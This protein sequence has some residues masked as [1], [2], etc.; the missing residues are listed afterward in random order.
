[1][2]YWDGLKQ[3]GDLGDVSTTN[4]RCEST[5][6]TIGLSGGSG[7]SFLGYSTRSIASLQTTTPGFSSSLPIYAS[8]G[9]LV[10][11]SWATAFSG[12]A[13]TNVL[14]MALL[15]IFTDM[16]ALG[17]WTGS[18]Y[19]GSVSAN[20]CLDWTSPSAGD[21]GRRGRS[22]QSTGAWI[23]FSD[24]VC[25]AVIP[26]FCLYVFDD[27]T[28]S[29]TAPTLRPVT[30]PLTAFP[31]TEFP[32]SS[33]TTGTPTLS[34]STGFPTP[35]PVESTGIPT[36]SPTPYPTGTLSP[37][38]GPQ[39]SLFETL[40]QCR[41]VMGPDPVV[42]GGISVCNGHG[43]LTL[44]QSTE[45]LSYTILGISS[46][47]TEI[48]SLCQQGI[49]VG[50]TIYELVEGDYVTRVVQTFAAAG[51]GYYTFLQGRAGLTAYHST[52][53]DTT[54][55]AFVTCSQQLPPVCE[56]ACDDGTLVEFVC[57]NEGLWQAGQDVSPKPLQ[58]NNN[59]L[60]FT[61]QEPPPLPA[62]SSPTSSPTSPTAKPTT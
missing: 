2:L 40:L 17:P 27:Y 21:T 52:S 10:A 56:L 11:T 20:T 38:T 61:F 8:T 51:E 58:L 57:L 45:I 7:Y 48:H 44:S 60:L 32:T 5:A 50:D 41:L 28:P 3:T 18:N 55:C 1:M 46:R 14:E 36:G 15:D 54:E 29:P 13:I 24:P 30:P 37:T 6:T 43:Q 39:L 42:G 25:S 33:P 62:T 4:A 12:D 34:P 23:E 26:M 31:T 59:L 9:D 16:G 49:L 19:D 47:G 53:V 22:S 35:S